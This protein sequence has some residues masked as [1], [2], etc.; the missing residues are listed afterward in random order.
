MQYLLLEKERQSIK[1]QA[2]QD[3]ESYNQM[4]NLK[5][6]QTGNNYTSGVEQDEIDNSVSTSLFIKN[7]IEK[8]QRKDNPRSR[9][10][11][12]AD[13]SKGGSG[14][15][16]DRLKPSNLKKKLM[17]D[18]KDIRPHANRSNVGTF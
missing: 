13:S 10:N 7:L 18:I 15:K 11:T 14:R 3:Q 16:T 17:D 4:Q 1:Q 5:L 8:M 6:D 12:E 9:L 2:K